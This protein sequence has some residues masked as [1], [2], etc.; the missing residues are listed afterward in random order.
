MC[1]KSQKRREGESN[2]VHLTAAMNLSIVTWDDKFVN[3]QVRWAVFSHNARTEA[4]EHVPPTARTK[5]PPLGRASRCARGAEH[6]VARRSTPRRSF[7]T[8]RRSWKLR[9]QCRWRSRRSCTAASTS[10]TREM[11]VGGAKCKGHAWRMCSCTPR[12]YIMHAQGACTQR[13][14]PTHLALHSP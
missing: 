4:H 6:R 7:L 2:L 14:A 13:H 5:P 8:S 9:R 12:H 11:P 3:I 10:R 1:G